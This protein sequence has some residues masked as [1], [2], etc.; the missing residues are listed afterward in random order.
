[1]LYQTNGIC[2]FSFKKVKE[3]RWS[4]GYAFSLIADFLEF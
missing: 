1:M 3:P 2:N 4:Y